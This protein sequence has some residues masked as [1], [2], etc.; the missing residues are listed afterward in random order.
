MLEKIKQL[1]NKLNSSNSNND[2]V[3]V[4]SESCD[5]DVKKILYYTYNPFF[6]YNVT[7]KNC[8]KHQDVC[9]LENYINNTIIDLLDDL[10]LRRITGNEAI[11]SVNGFVKINPHYKE[12]IFSIID[13]DLKTRTG[14]KLINKAIPN[15]IPTFN[16]ALAEKYE[17]DMLETVTN[18][19]TKWYVSRKLDGVRCI[20][21]VDDNGDVK[22]YSRQGKLFDT[23]G[24][25]ENEIRN[26]GLTNVVFDGEICMID[27]NGNE[28]FQDVMKEIR[29]KDHT[30][31]NALFKIFDCL[32]LDEFTRCKGDTPLQTRLVHLLA[33]LD[34]EDA[35]HISILEQEMVTNEEKLQEW[36]DKASNQ[37]WE[38]IMLRKNIGYEGK[39]TKNLLKVKTFHDDEYVVKRIESNSIRH[40]VDGVDIEEVM[41]SKIIVEHKGNEVGVGSGFT[42]EQR[43]SFHH[44]PSLIVGKTVTVQYFEE[45]QNMDGE[46]SLRFP[47]LKYIFENG[48]DV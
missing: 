15:L 21:V 25:V 33:F 10:R 42:M 7:S 17:P 40:I 12:I 29:R 22:S 43:R 37:G 38:G 48:R 27:D 46:Y 41:L 34:S 24:V 26:I 30:M 19:P 36:I 28:S 35:P 31:T 32:S 8:I 16:V 14:E 2:K 1:V 45:S 44:D 13:K 47:V 20:I 5:D 11:A 4:L 6:Q 23:L 18:T 39:R 3:R 9:K